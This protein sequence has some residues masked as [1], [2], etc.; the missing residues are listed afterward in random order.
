[1]STHNFGQST[2]SRRGSQRPTRKG[3]RVNP[4][5]EFRTIPNG[6][7]DRRW[8]KSAYPA[9]EPLRLLLSA[10]KGGRPY[11]V[12]FCGFLNLIVDF[13][14]VWGWIGFWPLL[15]LERQ[16]TGSWLQNH[17]DPNSPGKAQRHRG[18]PA[19]DELSFYLRLKIT[20]LM[21][22]SGVQSIMKAMAVPT[23]RHALFF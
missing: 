1:M 14:W 6:C 11:A 7:E 8:A 2:E 9:R 17:C 12:A 21:H 23:C 19:T 3:H 16:I 20:L 22:F 15:R 4:E 5:F 10:G 13:S 18:K